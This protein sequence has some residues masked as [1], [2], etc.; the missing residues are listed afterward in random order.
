MKNKV[1]AVIGGFIGLFG[2]G[3]LMYIVIFGDATFHLGE[4]SSGFL[5][6]PRFP[7]IIAMEILYAIFLTH[8]FSKWAQIKTF[9]TGLK[10]GLVIGFFI[11][12][13]ASLLRYATTDLINTTGILFDTAT[14]TV[15]F[16]VAGGLVGY[17]LGK[18]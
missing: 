10:A 15:R 6:E 4:G 14:S 5:A 11:A 17:F 18:E 12:L 9:S 13:T 7:Y 16:A 1:L 3:Y 2:L 8:I